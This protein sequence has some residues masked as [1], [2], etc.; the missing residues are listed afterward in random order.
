MVTLESQYLTLLTMSGS[1]AVLGAVYD[2]YRT[3]LKHWRFLRWLGPFLDL[4]FWA[5]AF[6]LVFSLS[7]WS[8]DGE[9]RLSIFGL[10]FAGFILYALFFRRWVVASA[11]QLVKTV[12]YVV[13][14]L[15]RLLIV[16]VWRP[17]A[18]TGSL[19]VRLALFVLQLLEWCE[20]VLLWPLKPLEHAVTRWGQPIWRPVDRT[21]RNILA[22]KRNFEKR[23]KE[24]RK[25]ASNWWKH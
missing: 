21:A 11:V 24:F 12:Q 15:W 7:L 25:K 20:P 1:G 8:N 10:L 5:G 6:V 3:V 16:L 18:G 13:F 4:G 22:A 9:F 17:V 19:L 2:I 23:W 14:F